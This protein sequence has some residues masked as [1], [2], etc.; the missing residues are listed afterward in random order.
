MVIYKRE[1]HDG[2]QHYK[3]VEYFGGEKNINYRF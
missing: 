2:E 3:P 1:L